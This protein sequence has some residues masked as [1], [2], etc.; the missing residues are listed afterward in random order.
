M[1]LSAYHI[2]HNSEHTTGISLN[3][4]C[5]HVTP[6]KNQ[7]HLT[8]EGVE[9]CTSWSCPELY[10]CLISKKTWTYFQFVYVNIMLHCFLRYQ[11]ILHETWWF[12]YC[13]TIRFQKEDSVRKVALLHNYMF[14][15]FVLYILHLLDLQSCITFPSHW[16]SFW[17]SRIRILKIWN[18]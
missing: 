14:N 12:E 4:Y 6:C 15:T 13:E 10:T 18:K 5:D 11:L 8:D 1:F 3:Y 9:G 7:F 16:T 17:I 2:R